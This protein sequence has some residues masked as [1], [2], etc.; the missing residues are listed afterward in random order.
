MSVGRIC[1]RE[2]DIITMDESAQ[3]AARRMH[4]RKV[5]TLVVVNQKREPIGIITDRDLA[6]RVVAPGLSGVDVPVREVMTSSPTCVREQTPIE[7]VLVAMRAGPFRRI[8]V[9]ADDGTLAGVVSLDDILELL[10]EEFVSISRL[11]RA[12]EPQSLGM[13][14]T[15]R[16]PT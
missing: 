2:V 11:I 7:D 16:K 14:D 15:S 6:V 12:E 5:G 9:V 3:V 1:V 10:A 8:P 13:V 4:D